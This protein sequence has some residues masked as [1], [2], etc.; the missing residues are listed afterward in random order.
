VGIDLVHERDSFEPN[1]IDPS[2]LSCHTAILAQSGS[3]KSFM[4]GRLI[5]ELLIK[6][7][8]R[9]VILDP[10]SDFVRLPQI[11][12][13]VWQRPNFQQSFFPGENN[14]YFQTAWSK[15]SINV[16]SNRNLA[17][18]QPL[19]I[20]WGGLTDSER[21]D[22][23]DLNP[24]GQPELYW[25]LVLAGEVARDRWDNPAESDYDFEF[26]THVAYEICEFLMGGEAPDDIVQ[27]QFAQGLRPIGVSLSLRFRALISQL[28]AFDIWRSVGD[29]DKDIAEILPSHI[30]NPFATVIDLLSVDS[31]AERIALAT[32]ILASLWKS[33]RDSYSGALRDLEDPDRR[34]PTFLVI[35]EAHN[36][37]P[38]HRTSPAAERLANDV[39]RIAA[40]G[41]KFGLF[42]IVIT[43]RPR[44][45]EPS[46]L[47]EC[48]ALLLM[49]MT[50]RG[51]LEYASEVFGFLPT[52]RLGIAT[53]L[54]V[55]DVLLYGRL[56]HNDKISHVAPRRTMQGG[57]S[58]DDN[59]WMNPY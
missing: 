50:N 14:E 3:G 25:L 59:F 19:R 48:D 12:A 46:I 52:D 40:E 41:R 22:V 53:E 6:T 32:R 15:V 2:C 55:G 33:A 58:L 26:F 17:H 5:E 47:S 21:A 7:K 29:N 34:V 30:D 27:N 37:V 38:A 45:L 23:M 49:K 36:I 1:S 4:V 16:L 35:D 11:D 31:D 43:Q 51:D 57:K 13:A 42:L 24:I 9:V 10:N 39:I 18:A 8:A 56:G 44:K 54:K 28:D 20:N